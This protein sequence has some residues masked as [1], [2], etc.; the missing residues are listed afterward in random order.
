[1]LLLAL[2]V[3]TKTKCL[4]KSS[5]YFLH[6]KSDKMCLLRW[7]FPFF[8]L[9][10][11]ILVSTIFIILHSHSSKVRLS[12]F[13]F[14]AHFILYACSNSFFWLVTQLILFCSLYDGPF[15]SS[16]LS[17]LFSTMPRLPVTTC[18]TGSYLKSD[19]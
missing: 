13:S 16:Y 5:R 19:T 15:L 3:G 17:F 18:P 14:L 11:S 2:S 8:S 10:L 1:M 6:S 7:F 9:S 12:T 4:W